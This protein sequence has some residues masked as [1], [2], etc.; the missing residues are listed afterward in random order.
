MMKRHITI[1]N[2]LGNSIVYII[3]YLLI[4]VIAFYFFDRDFK[5]DMIL[6]SVIASLITSFF[7]EFY[8]L[9]RK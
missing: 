2:I 5:L 7:L 3:T 6:I 4:N 9:K 8:N 1:K